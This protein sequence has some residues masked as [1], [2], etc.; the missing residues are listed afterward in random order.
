MSSPPATTFARIERLPPYVFSI[1]SE[2]KMAA[3]RRGEDIID[4]GM[5]NPDGPTPKHIV[6]KLVETVQRPDTHGYSVSKGIPRLRRAI[7]HWYKRRWD[8]EFDPET[9][10][11]VT[12]GSKEG[13][14][15]LA[16]ATLGRGDTVLVPNPSYPIHIYGP[17]IAGRRH[18][19]GADDAR[20]GLLRRARAHHQD[21]LS[22]AEDAHHQLSGE[23]D[24]AVRRAAVLREDRR[25]RQGVRHLRHSRPRVRRHHV[26]RLEG[27]VDHAGAGRARRRRRV[28]HDVEELQHGGL[29]HRLHGR[30]PRP[31]RT[32]CRASRAI[33]TTA[34]SRRSR[35][36]PSPRSKAR[37]SASRKSPPSTRR[38]AT[39]CARGCSNPAGPSKSR[40]RRCTC[41]RRF[42]RRIASSARSS[43]RSS[44]W[45]KA[46]VSVSPGIGF[47]EYGDGH[48]RFAMIENE[49]RTRQAI[50][51]I[52]QMF[53]EDGLLR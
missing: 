19:P 28:L 18:L 42:R 38:A 25:A 24:G 35:W 40:R 5:G 29:A 36:R 31:R 44:C 15:H 20:R 34:R 30:Q 2:L 51:G 3:R 23:S 12:I 41:G 9:E 50:R 1:T 7:C 6:D 27:A 43:S 39:C 32:R 46:K 11:I 22:E 21:E 14:A 52:K 4:F 37:R 47:G 53:R 48:V 16:L 33:T 13:I 45:R 26:R 8:V 49:A 10:A 17:V